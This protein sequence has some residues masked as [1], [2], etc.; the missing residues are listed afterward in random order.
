MA[1]GR[2]RLVSHGGGFFFS[3]F[4]T[5][6]VSPS[7][8]SVRPT[9]GL[10]VGLLL[11]RPVTVKP[12]VQAFGQSA[13]QDILDVLNYEIYGNCGTSETETG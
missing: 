4:G 2:S 8:L 9:A 6:Q 5:I 11:F 13:V 10:H 12:A 7:F 1:D 3:T